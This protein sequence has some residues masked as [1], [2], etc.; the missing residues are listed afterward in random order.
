MNAEEAKRLTLESKAK[1]R[2][3]QIEDR[4]LF[5]DCVHD[6]ILDRISQGHGKVEIDSKTFDLPKFNTFLKDKDDEFIKHF[7]KLGYNIFWYEG[8]NS[9]DD[10]S[11][12]QIFWNFLKNQ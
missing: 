10:L 8:Q 5:I 2:Q 6:K 1:K 3:Q 12:Y 4:K 11:C 9:E 7:T